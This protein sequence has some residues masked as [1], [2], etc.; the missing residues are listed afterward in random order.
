MTS[1]CLSCTPLVNINEKEHSLSHA[2]I[3]SLSHTLT[4]TLSLSLSLSL[5][6]SL[7][8]S[9]SLPLP[10][11]SLLSSLSWQLSDWQIFITELN[12]GLL[13]LSYSLSY[14]LYSMQYVTTIRIHLLESQLHCYLISH[15]LA[16]V[17]SCSF[18]SF[19]RHNTQHHPSGT[20]PTY[21]HNIYRKLP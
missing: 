7:S 6:L 2:H 15:L 20:T 10:L 21:L 19:T 11:L 14:I 3:L 4:L 9:H 12:I 18:F 5:F 8:R 1:V 13:Q 17:H 16:A